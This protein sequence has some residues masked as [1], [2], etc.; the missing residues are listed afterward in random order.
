[1]A[2]NL[3]YSLADQDFHHTKSIGVWNVSMQLL[4]HLGARPE[5][6][7]LTVFTNPSQS[8]LTWPAKAALESHPRAATSRLGRILWDQWGVYR[9]A[10]QS[11]NDWLLLPKGF[12]SFVGRCPVRLA[13]FVHD[14]MHD[15]YQRHY[16]PNPLAR[17][18]GYFQRSLRATLRHANIIFTNSDFTRREVLRLAEEWKLNPP[19]VVAAGIGFDPRPAST[20]GPREQIVVLAGR[21]PHKCTRLAVDYLQHWASRPD[22]N[23]PVT[24]VGALPPGLTLPPLPGWTH[25]ERLPLADYDAVLGRAIVL[26]YFSAYEGFGMPPV[27]ATLAGAT[28]VY[29]DIPA[30]RE[31]MGG[32]GFPFANDSFDAFARALD[33]ALRSSFAQR[34]AWQ[35]QLRSRHTWAAVAERVVNGLM[36]A[37]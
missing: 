8:T 33:D 24:W 34:A 22:A 14:A 26:V 37:T 21:W 15:H 13:A 27:E 28:A 9:A 19:Q 11:R 2:L 7:R 36:T 1:M 35:D 4:Q 10:Q 6:G 3:T 16:Q 25:H 32:C 31:S 18:A 29:S 12:A 30:M 17:E 23:R 20:A 5:I